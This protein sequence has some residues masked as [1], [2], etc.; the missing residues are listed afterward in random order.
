M[1]HNLQDTLVCQPTCR[2]MGVLLSG[3]RLVPRRAPGQH[4]ACATTAPDITHP[5]A[6]TAPDTPHPTATTAPDITHPTA[7]TAPDITHPTATMCGSKHVAA[8]A[9]CCRGCGLSHFPHPG[10]HHACAT[11]RLQVCIEAYPIHTANACRTEIPIY[12]QLTK[13]HAA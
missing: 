3:V 6:T 10:Q 8:W 7:T 1:I 5:T 12:D 2:C 4:H 13:H 9:C 11:T